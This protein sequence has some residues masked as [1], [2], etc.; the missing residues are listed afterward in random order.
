MISIIRKKS[1]KLT[2]NVRDADKVLY[3]GEAKAVS[4]F[5]KQGP[6]DILPYHAHFISI[7]QKKITV[8]LDNNSEQSFVIETGVMRVESDTVDVFLG[9]ETV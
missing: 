3:D 2:V 7:I 8:H 4:S 9:I 5:N 6:F 1:P